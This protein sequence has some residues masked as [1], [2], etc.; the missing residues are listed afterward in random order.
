MEM[1][2]CG[3]IRIKPFLYSKTS[4]RTDHC[5]SVT[6]NLR[7]TR[8]ACSA[9]YLPVVIRSCLAF[10]QPVSSPTRIA[11]FGGLIAHVEHLSNI[12]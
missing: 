7:L 9:E 12:V 10:P 3:L 6:G 11:L 1:I 8:R 2:V 5:Q 4:C